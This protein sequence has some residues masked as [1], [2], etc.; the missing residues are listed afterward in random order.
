[1]Y[2]GWNKYALRVV[3]QERGDFA[4]KVQDLSGDA[5][6]SESPMATYCEIIN[7]GSTTPTN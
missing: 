6:G 5:E 4:N 3:K 7:I 1:M 2:S